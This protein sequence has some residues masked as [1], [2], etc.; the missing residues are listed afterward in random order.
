MV[1]WIVRSASADWDADSLVLDRVELLPEF[2]PNR[3]W[4]PDAASA[5]RLRARP[6]VVSLGVQALGRGGTAPGSPALLRAA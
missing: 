4:L 2:E 1:P 3:L 6:G 5:V